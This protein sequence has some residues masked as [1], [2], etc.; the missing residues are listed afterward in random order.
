M[1]DDYLENDYDEYRDDDLDQYDDDFS[2]TLPCPNCGKEIY[3]DA[4]RCPYCGEYVVFTN[5]QWV[6]RPL[7][8]ILLGIL[9]ILATIVVFAL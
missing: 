3:E 4:E 6:G 7:W 1:D 9:G 8:W 2:E 5:S